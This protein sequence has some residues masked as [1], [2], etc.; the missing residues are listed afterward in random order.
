MAERQVWCRVR[1]VAPGGDEAGRYSLEGYGDPDL[2]AVDVV[3]RLGLLAGR[4][5]QSLVLEQVSPGMARLLE[6]AGLG[7]YV[8]GQP[9]GRE[10]PRRV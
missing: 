1:L 8:Q 9:E 4:Q 3:A 5:D 6:L 2:T 10:Q 7:V